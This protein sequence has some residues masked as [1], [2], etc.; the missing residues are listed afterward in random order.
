VGQLVFVLVIGLIAMAGLVI[1]AG[2]LD[3]AE[4]MTRG[5]P[6]RGE[7]CASRSPAREANDY[8]P[9]IAVGEQVPA[10]P[11]EEA[12]STALVW[13]AGFTPAA[14]TAAT[15]VRFGGRPRER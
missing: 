9:T 7:G 8:S 14:L 2:A 6:W 4:M 10:H 5:R 15:W 13:L 12:G 11:F 3:G 1:A